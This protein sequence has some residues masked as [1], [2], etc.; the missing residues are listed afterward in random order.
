M[1]KILVGAALVATTLFGTAACDTGQTGGKNHAQ[2]IVAQ[3]DKQNTKQDTTPAD[4]TP[5]TKAAAP[6]YTGSQ[7]QAIGTASDYL[8][9]QSFSRDGLIAQL[10]YEGFTQFQAVYGVNH[11][12]L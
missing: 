11:A 1:K 7:E 6:K 2:K 12:G 9:G 8:D 3:Q 4:N 5:A 10:K